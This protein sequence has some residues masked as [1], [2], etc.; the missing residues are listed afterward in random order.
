MTATIMLSC[1][2]FRNDLVK[3]GG[4]N[5]VIH[6]AIIDFSNTTRLFKRDT[7]FSITT[8]EDNKILIARIG[9]NGA[10]I[11]L[12]RNAKIG[13]RNNQI[14]TRFIEKKGKLFLWWDDDYPLTQEALD[15]YKK[16]NLLQDDRGGIITVPDFTN[17]DA[18]KAA[19]YYFCKNDLTRY[20]K[21]ITNI[22][23]G[24]YDPPSVECK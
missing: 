1:S 23:L 15:I 6:N 16:Y 3:T 17:D 5:G 18:Q 8:G 2:S 13:A 10:K 4:R 21:V 24:Y 7:F 20:K 14:P 22:G 19:H 9:K 12:T 11:L